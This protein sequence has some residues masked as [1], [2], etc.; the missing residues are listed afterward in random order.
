MLT[1]FQF[2]ELAY[3]LAILLPEGR[4]FWIDNFYNYFLDKQYLWYFLIFVISY[5]PVWVQPFWS[6][7]DTKAKAYFALLDNR[8]ST[9]HL[10]LD[11]WYMTHD[12]WHIAGGEHFLQISA[13]QLLRFGIDSVLKILN[14]MMAKAFLAFGKL[15][16]GIWPRL[17][18]MG[19]ESIKSWTIIKGS[20]INKKFTFNSKVIRDSKVNLN[21]KVNRNQKV[22]HELKVN[23]S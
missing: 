4:I 3:Y 8:P 19:G 1:N 6:L 17:W 18:G 20:L 11:T 14:K 2:P 7:S 13:P 21:S 5:L 9:W 15:F 10:T 12:M 16:F 22:N 23:H